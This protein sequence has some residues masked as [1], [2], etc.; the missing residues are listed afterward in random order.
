VAEPDGEDS[1]RYG[2]LEPVR[3]YAREKLEVSNQ[4]EQILQRHAEYYLAFAEK[5]EPE[6]NGPDQA[7]WLER[8]EREHDNLRAARRWLHESKQKEAGLRLAG[9]LWRLWSTHGYLEEGQRWL[10]EALAGDDTPSLTRSKVLNGAGG[11]AWLRGDLQRARAYLE[12]TL[13]MSQELGDRP[14]MARA[15]T[16][17]ANVISAL[18]DHA[19]AKELLERCLALDRELDDTRGI[20]YSLGGLGD[21]A[22]YQGEFEQAGKYYEESLELHRKLGDKRSVGL[23][24]NSLGAVARCTGELQRAEELFEQSLALVREIDDRWITVLLLREIGCLLLEQ[25]RTERAARVL[26]A[27]DRHRSEIGLELEPQELAEYD[28]AVERARA[29]L[30]AQA[31]QAAWSLGRAMTLD[32]AADHALSERAELDLAT[33][34]SAKPQPATLTSRER[35]VAALIAQGL[36]NRQIAQELHL[37][38]RTVDTHVGKIL[39]KLGLHTRARISDWVM[40]QGSLEE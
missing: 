25:N 16:N 34:K 3:Q 15:L 19:R 12:Q 37:S 5:A 24:L 35:E 23:T 21:I 6:L 20:A 26:G 11:F 18:G 31:F 36:T 13:A 2:M 28:R 32:E 17:L 8:L 4:A 33:R 30:G 10:E 22:F 14:G 29:E 7:A 27:A 9:A 40:K 39:H 1:F 38:R